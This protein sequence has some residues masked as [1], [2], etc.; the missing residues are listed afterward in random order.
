MGQGT[1]MSP[2]VSMLFQT[3]LLPLKYLIETFNILYYY[4]CTLLLYTTAVHCCCTPLLY[5]TAVH[6]CC[7]LLLYTIAV[8]YCYTL[9]LYTTAVQFDRGT[10]L[11]KGDNFSN[12]VDPRVNQFGCSIWFLGD[13]YRGE[14]GGKYGVKGDVSL[15]VCAALQEESMRLL[16]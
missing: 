7:T 15:C 13:L 1:E 3:F 11:A 16:C 9:L 6:Y 14:R 5:I 2:L 12:Q 10:K 8:D 4:Y